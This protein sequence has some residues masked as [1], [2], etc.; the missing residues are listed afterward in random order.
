MI[1]KTVLANGLRLLTVPK[2]DGLSVSALVLVGVGTNYETEKINGL[3]HFLEHMCF[4]GT[5][6]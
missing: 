2:E 5:T 3:S 4:K 6:K 1:N